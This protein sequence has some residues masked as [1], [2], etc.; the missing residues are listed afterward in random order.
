MLIMSRFLDSIAPAGTQAIGEHVDTYWHDTTEDTAFEHRFT[1]GTGAPAAFIA[2][3]RAGRY[4]NLPQAE[5]N[6]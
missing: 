1:V 4:A 6:S 3:I 2:E 5:Y